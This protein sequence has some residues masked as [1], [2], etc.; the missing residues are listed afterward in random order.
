[1]DTAKRE[2]KEETG[3]TVSSVEHISPPTFSSVGMTDESIVYVHVYCN[4][5]ITNKNTETDE[6]IET[7]AYNTRELEVLWSQDINWGAKAWPYIYNFIKQG[8]IVF[9]FARKI[10]SSPKV[11]ENL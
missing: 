9:N 7:R 2:L 5:D 8:K 4:G 3:L 11:K 6:D 10:K 1:V